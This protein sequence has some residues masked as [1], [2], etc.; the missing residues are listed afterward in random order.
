[1]NRNHSRESRGAFQDFKA[2]DCREVMLPQANRGF[3]ISSAMGY[4]LAGITL[5][6]LFGLIVHFSAVSAAAGVVL[7]NGPA[8]VTPTPIET[9]LEAFMTEF[10][11]YNAKAKEEIK[12]LGTVT[13]ETKTAIES[14]NGTLK[15]MQTQLDAVDKRTQQAAGTD[16]NVKTLADRIFETAEYQDHKKTD[17]ML[18]KKHLNWVFEG[19][20]FQRKTISNIGLGNATSGVLSPVRIP[21]IFDMAR[22]ALRIRDVM[23][24]RTQSTGNSFDYLYQS[25]RTNNASPQHEGVAKSESDLNWQTG[26]GQIRTIAHFVTC[27]RQSLS[28]NPWLRGKVDEELMYGL[29]VK[30]EAQILSGDGTGINLNGLITQAT[31]FDTALLVAS[32]GWTRLDVL[33]YAKLQARLAGLATYAPSAMVLHPYDMAKIELTK[34]ANGLYIV[35]D[36]KTGTEVKFVWDLPTVESDSIPQGTFLVGAF[37]TAADLIDREQVSVDISFE[38]A[39]NFT[40]NKAT[41]LCEERIGLAVEKAAAFIKGTFTTSPATT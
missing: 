17:F 6:V 3:D 20:I 31:A 35:G 12:N 5:L 8:A 36:P 18:G 11:E 9:K 32:A 10:K 29:K 28:D 21:G 15:E 26:S 22:Q 38:H 1:M 40:E 7:A 39:N 30:E 41:I 37:N 23:R 2:L 14:L 16:A 13:V 33:R 4:V 27:T 34:D 19:G 25:T 24:V